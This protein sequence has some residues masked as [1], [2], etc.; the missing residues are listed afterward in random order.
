MSYDVKLNCHKLSDSQVQA[1]AKLIDPSNV[2]VYVEGREIIAK[3]PNSEIISIMWKYGS[4]FKLSPTGD[5]GEHYDKF[6]NVIADIRLINVIKSWFRRIAYRHGRKIIAGYGVKVGEK[7]HDLW[8]NE[9]IIKEI[10]DKDRN[11]FGSIIYMY[12]DGRESKEL[13]IDKPN[14]IKSAQQGD[15]PEAGSSE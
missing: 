15:A 3:N 5:D 12:G 11:G 2:I 4:A 14:Y 10:F 8:G 7:Y 13:I 9:L 6:G 1:L